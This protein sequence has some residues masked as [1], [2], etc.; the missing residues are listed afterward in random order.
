MARMDANLRMERLRGKGN[1]RFYPIQK[2]DAFPAKDRDGWKE[3]KDSD[4]K[5]SGY[6]PALQA[7]HVK[8]HR[9]GIWKASR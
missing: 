9:S 1:G 2:W 8:S 3:I 7:V 5:C 6:A 4:R